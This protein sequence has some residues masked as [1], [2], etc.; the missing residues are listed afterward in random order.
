RRTDSPDLTVSSETVVE[1]VRVLAVG[2]KIKR[3]KN[4]GADAPDANIRARTV[5]LE[6]TPCMGEVVSVAARLGSLSLALRSFATETRDPA[7]SVAAASATQPAPIWAGDI[8]R[9]VGDLPRSRKEQ[10]NASAHA[11]VAAAARPLTIYRGSD[12]ND[13]SADVAQ[14]A[15]S[16]DAPPLPSVLAK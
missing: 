11:P 2:S 15:A 16:S 13:G 6:V 3:P 5:T 4:N 14:V 1:H 8:S 12:K 9:A 7:K 10:T